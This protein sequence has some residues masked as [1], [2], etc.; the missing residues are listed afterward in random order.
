MVGLVLWAR[1]VHDKKVLTIRLVATGVLTLLMFFGIVPTFQT[2]GYAQIAGVV[3]TLAWGWCMAIIWVPAITGSIGNL[4]GSLY[5]GGT[6]EIEPKPFYSICLAQ[7]TKGNYQRA[8][9]EVRKQLDKFPLDFEG[10]LLLAEI[11][12]ENLNDLPGAEITIQRLCAKP[13]LAPRNL[14]YALNRLADWHLSL[15]KDRDAAQRDLEKIIELLPET[16]MSLQAA[17]RIGHL[18]DT[19]HLLASSDRQRISV[20]KGVENLGLIRDHG[21]LKLPD[22]DPGL[23][24]AEYV[25][26]LEQHPLDAHAREKLAVIY[27]GHFQRLDLATDQLEQLIQQPNQ[28]AKQVVHWLNMLADLQVQA[29]AELDNVRAT[30][31]R[32]IDQYPDLAAA[33]TAQR[34]LD[35]LKLELKAR[36]KVQ[37][38]PLGTY[39]QN[40]GLKKSAKV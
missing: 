39:E 13:E 31:Q 28:P 15:H 18:A 35:T 11:Q 33:G 10:M 8:L 4:F 25:R 3:F 21:K 16:E 20:K 1:R 34:R 38:V 12:A 40:L 2:G 22:P 23:A 30:L 36:Q 5:D 6:A 29:G 32:I 7:R 14:A 9:D 27:A 37:D 24:A 17:Q 26:H 19:E